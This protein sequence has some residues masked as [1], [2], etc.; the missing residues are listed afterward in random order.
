M[1]K[2]FIVFDCET[3]SYHYALSLSEITPFN[4][5]VIHSGKDLLKVEVKIS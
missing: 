5:W 2:W 1:K 3:R 4:Q